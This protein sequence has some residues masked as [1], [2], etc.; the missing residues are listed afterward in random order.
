VSYDA[1]GETLFDSLS[2][3]QRRELSA[4]LPVAERANVGSLGG[5]SEAFVKTLKL[6]YNRMSLL[7]DADTALRQI[8]GWTEDYD[9]IRHHSALKMPSPRQ[10]RQG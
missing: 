4:R 9:G 3:K 7:P 5:M 1:F 2:T 6:D 8:D 10:F